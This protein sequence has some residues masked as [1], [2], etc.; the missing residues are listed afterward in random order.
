MV[1]I[2][3]S[4]V[5][6]ILVG[7]MIYG[8][9]ENRK[10]SF[11]QRLKGAPEAVWLQIG[12]RINKYQGIK[13]DDLRKLYPT[14]TLESVREEKQKNLGKVIWFFALGINIAGLCIGVWSGSEGRIFQGHLIQ[15]EVDTGIQDKISLSVSGES[16]Y[17]D[18]MEILVEPKTPSTDQ[19]D[20]IFKDSYD[21]ILSQL[22]GENPSLME[23]RKPLNPVKT[24]PGIS[25]QVQWNF[26]ETNY[27]LEDGSLYTDAVLQEGSQTTIGLQLSYGGVTQNYSIEIKVFPPE[28]TLEDKIKAEILEALEIE[29][30]EKNIEEVLKLPESAAG[31]SLVWH[32][33]I[34]NP[35]LNLTI[36]GL[37]IL[38]LLIANNREQQN[39]QLKLRSEQLMEDYPDLIHQIVLLSSAG[40]NMTAVL[41]TILEDA[42]R[43][44]K[45]RYVYME[46]EAIFGQIHQGISEVKAFE[47]FGKRCGELAY[48]KLGTMMAQYVTKGAKGISGLMETMAD[49]AMHMRRENARRKGEIA[50]TRLLMPMGVILVVVFTILIIPAFLS[51][52]I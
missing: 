18:Q 2:N 6:L 15:R 42:K 14:H 44:K 24:V 21:Y 3:G 49:E 12:Q 40:M 47:M 52:N 10:K 11:M 25:M 4:L 51:M 35:S 29:N 22:Q 38:V 34:S 46:L 36:V 31:Q 20:T 17:I 19:L 41:K 13:N 48:I 50:G 43:Q 33:K 30:S 5:V 27:I 39:K 45:Q 23:V 28:L 7:T 9:L 16:F 8:H 1:W 32:E 37:I 26:L